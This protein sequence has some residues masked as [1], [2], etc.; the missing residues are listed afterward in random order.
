MDKFIQLVDSNIVINAY[1]FNLSII[2]NVWLYKNKIFTEDEL[3]GQ[4]SLPILVEVRTKNFNLNLV[5][6]RLK[7]SIKPGYQEPNELLTS[8]VAKIVK[9]LP[10]TPYSASGLNFIYHVI[11]EDKN[12]VK[13][14]R[15][16][17][18]QANSKLMQNFDS[19]DAR[20]GSYFSKDVIGTRLKLDVKPITVMATGK[21]EDRLQFAFNFHINFSSNNALDRIL[22]LISKWDE[23]KNLSDQIMNNID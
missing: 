22:N 23:A 10:H 15:S 7:F 11:P 9:L 3:K 1:E 14:S 13:L 2:N 18:F 16:L 6:N 21:E 19:E 8:I 5:P 17:F 12:I 20:F 4:K